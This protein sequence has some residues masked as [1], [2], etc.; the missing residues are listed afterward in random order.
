MSCNGITIKGDICVREYWLRNCCGNCKDHCYCENYEDPFLVKPNIDTS[1][2]LIDV[3]TNNVN[4]LIIHQEQP[5]SC[6]SKV[7]VRCTF[8]DNFMDKIKVLFEDP[9]VLQNRVKIP[10]NVIAVLE[11]LVD[12][13]YNNKE[14]SVLVDVLKIMDSLR[15][16]REYV[17]KLLKHHKLQ[18][19]VFHRLLIIRKLST[20]I[21]NIVFELY[22]SDIDEQIF[23]TDGY[24]YSNN[25]TDKT[26]MRIHDRINNKKNKLYKKKYMELRDKK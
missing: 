26:L 24:I 4:I 25:K 9:M 20:Y 3:P 21:Q 6:K 14:V 2:N 5:I 18:F 10:F 15:V 11:S 7:G 23:D 13:R 8:T 22:I 16:K 1:N 19:Y 12:D 17:V